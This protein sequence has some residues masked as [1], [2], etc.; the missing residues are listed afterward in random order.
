M[1]ENIARTL[2]SNRNAANQS[3][4]QMKNCNGRCYETT[5]S[6]KERILWM[7]DTADGIINY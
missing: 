7:L 3:I 2:R 4:S 1:Q 6:N 5:W